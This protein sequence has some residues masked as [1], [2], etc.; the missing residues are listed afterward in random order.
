MNTQPE[1]Y[2][3]P[4][5]H[6][7]PQQQQPQPQQPVVIVQHPEQPEQP[8]QYSTLSKVLLYISVIIPP[9]PVI[10]VATDA[11]DIFINLCLLFLFGVGALFHSIYIVYKYTSGEKSYGAWIKKYG[12]N[13]KRPSGGNV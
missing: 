11:N 7:Q 3:Y 1:D 10:I 9:I 12:D 2:K 4:E 6:Q 13:E 5:Q 8:R